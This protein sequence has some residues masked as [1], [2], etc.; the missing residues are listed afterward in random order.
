[1]HTNKIRTKLSN[2]LTTLIMMDLHHPPNDTA[3]L[4]AIFTVNW[5]SP[6]FRLR[7]SQNF[8]S[9]RLSGRDLVPQQLYMTE[10]CLFPYHLST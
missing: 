8:S 6:S 1:M 9:V 2:C 10:F 5:H 7:T 3:I 4:T